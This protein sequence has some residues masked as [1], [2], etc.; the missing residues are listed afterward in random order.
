MGKMKDYGIWLEERGYAIWDTNIDGYV[1]LDGVDP[2]KTMSE[3]TGELYKD[4]ENEVA[5]SG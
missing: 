2:E 4:H 1:F 3:Y 5:N